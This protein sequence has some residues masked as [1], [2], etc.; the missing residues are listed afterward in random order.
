MSRDRTKDLQALAGGVQTQALREQFAP[1]KSSTGR[2]KSIFKKKTFKGEPEYP[3]SSFASFLNEDEDFAEQLALTLKGSH[4][5]FEEGKQQCAQLRAL[6]VEYN[7]SA[8]DSQIKMNEGKIREK[9]KELDT[10]TRK[11]QGMEKTLEALTPT[12][13]FSA[14][15]YRQMKNSFSQSYHEHMTTLFVLR[16]EFDKNQANK[17]HQRQEIFKNVYGFDAAT[18]EG[19]LM[20]AQIDVEYIAEET[21]KRHQQMMELERTMST[22]LQLNKDMALFV[23]EQQSQLDSIES[24]VSGTSAAMDLTVAE[25]H[26]AR[27]KQSSARIKKATAVGIGAGAAVAGG[28]SFLL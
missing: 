27:N 24:S 19:G 5:L 20:F 9:V 13:E 16:G 25:L 4:G 17:Q 1:A 12:T 18:T 10:L 28:A 14:R 2:F 3:S 26:A 15:M 6:Y 23:H 11:L 8:F 21:K 22:L 7:V